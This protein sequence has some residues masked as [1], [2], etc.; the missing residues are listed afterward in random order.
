MRTAWILEPR[1]RFS[2]TLSMAIAYVRYHIN[3]LFIE[4]YASYCAN[5]SCVLRNGEIRA[6]DFSDARRTS[7]PVE[8]CR[9]CSALS[10]VTENDTKVAEG[11]IGQRS[12]QDYVNAANA[13]IDMAEIAVTLIPGTST[14]ATTVAKVVKYAPVARQVL[15]KLPEVAPVAK[16][17]TDVIQQNAPNAVSASVG[18]VA[19]VAENA[20]S[21]VK[22][23]GNA[24]GDSVRAAV[25]ARAQ[26][27]ARKKARRVLLD[28]AGIRL[29]VAQ[30]LENRAAHGKLGHGV[31]KEYLAYSGC[32]AI[33]TYKS[34]VKNDDY[35]SFRDIYIGKSTDMGSGILADITG[36]GN[37][38]VYA[39]VKY[40]Q[41]VYVF[42]YPC[43]ADR[44]DELERSLITALDA[45]RSYNAMRV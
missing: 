25:D 20:F 23:K 32:Y 29:S 19:H 34:A 1:L 17:A 2:P 43:E 44:L 39:D 37:A 36:R 10:A 27:R 11:Q 16:K 7:R 40:K 12:A 6:S 15:N 26:E 13:V 33:A 31:G 45:D 35:S 21:S 8:C 3:W 9:G 41:H 42:L 30:F 38:D 28:G 4:N 18:Q 24:V 22:E 5:L 14:V